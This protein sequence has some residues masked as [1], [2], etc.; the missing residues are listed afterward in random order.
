MGSTGGRELPPDNGGAVTSSGVADDVEA[1]PRVAQEHV[2]SGSRRRHAGGYQAWEMR[3]R[4]E[5]GA[6]EPQICQRGVEE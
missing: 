2:R 4:A 1:R 3:M 6:R 5:Q